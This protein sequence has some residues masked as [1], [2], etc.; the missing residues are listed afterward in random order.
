MPWARRDAGVRPGPSLRR[1][2]APLISGEALLPAGPR[3]DVEPAGDLGR[4]GD[5]PGGDLAEQPHLRGQH[6]R[7]RWIGPV[8]QVD[9][10]DA[11]VA[12][13]GHEGRRRGDRRGRR[14][15]RASLRMVFDVGFSRTP[16]GYW[17]S[18]HRRLIFRL[19]LR[20]GAGHRGHELLIDSR[21]RHEGRPPGPGRGL[22]R[23]PPGSFLGTDQHEVQERAERPPPTRRGLSGLC[24]GGRQPDSFAEGR[25]G[26]L[27]LQ[28]GG[29]SRA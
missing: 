3:R 24:H 18:N 11:V 29:C 5:V 4:A 25:S 8:H 10:L 23:R 21:I 26:T 15:A 19:D 9:D 2:H 16:I 12:G 13:P 7:S 27:G 1:P 14:V 20:S 28:G 6:A 17:R 22:R